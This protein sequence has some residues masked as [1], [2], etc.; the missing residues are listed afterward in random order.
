MKKRTSRGWLLAR[1]QIERKSLIGVVL[2]HF[3]PAQFFNGIH[4]VLVEIDGFLERGAGAG[5]ILLSI[6][7]RSREQIIE[8]ADLRGLGYLRVGG[9]DRF[10]VILLRHI[11]MHQ[12]AKSIGGRWIFLEGLLIELLRFR[13]MLLAELDRTQFDVRSRTLRS[14]FHR[15]F[16]VMLGFAVVLTLQFRLASQEIA[17]AGIGLCRDDLL[18]G[19]ESCL[20]FAAAEFQGGQR[21]LC[22][23]QIR[24]NVNRGTPFGL[25]A[26]RVALL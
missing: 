11:N 24:V 8:I 3:H 10:V 26:P 21:F 5:I 12:A 22:L 16:R 14:P 18:R 17:I 20:I 4:V 13:E 19:I 25:R 15:L 9:G 6:V 7:E 2:L 23:D 1:L